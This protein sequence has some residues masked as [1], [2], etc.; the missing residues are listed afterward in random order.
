MSA[1]LVEVPISADNATLL[2]AAAESLD[3]H[4]GVVKTDSDGF[5]LVPQEVYDASGIG[6]EKKKPAKKAAKKAA[7]K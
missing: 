2:L 5:F 4:P 7:S 6:E 1:E 3:L